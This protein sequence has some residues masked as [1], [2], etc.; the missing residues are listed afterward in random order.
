[1]KLSGILLCIIIL[2]AS[3][4]EGGPAAYALCQAGCATVVV[5]CYAA[6]GAV[7]GTVTAGA[8]TAPAILACNIAF[9]KCSA[10][11]AAIALTPT[12]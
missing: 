8:A 9:G 6:A 7:F 4:I 2:T 3:C 5:A 1:M 10:V 12:P 11:C